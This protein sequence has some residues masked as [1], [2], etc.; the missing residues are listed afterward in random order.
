METD[1]RCPRVI[2]ISEIFAPVIV[3]SDSLRGNTQSAVATRS[4]IGRLGY[5]RRTSCMIINAH[6][7]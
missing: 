1:S 2:G 4:M 5:R 6:T 7:S 3:V